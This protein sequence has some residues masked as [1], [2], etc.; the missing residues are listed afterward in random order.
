MIIIA[1]ISGLAL[2]FLFFG[3]LW[4]TVRKSLGSKYTGLWFL[5]SSI[6]RIAVVLTGFYFIAQGSLIQLLI[7]VA[8]FIAARFLVLR[9]TKQIEQKQIIKTECKEV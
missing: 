8:G 2:G 3:G 6:S 4:F 5:G 1:L 7:S 9:I